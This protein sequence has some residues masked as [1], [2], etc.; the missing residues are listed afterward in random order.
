MP[1][2]VNSCM[3]VYVYG[4]SDKLLIKVIAHLFKYFK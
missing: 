4:N 3:Y 2:S 1:S